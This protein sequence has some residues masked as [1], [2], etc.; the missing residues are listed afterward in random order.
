MSIIITRV[1]KAL[2]HD[3]TSDY[4]GWC[5]QGRKAYPGEIQRK[6]QS[7]LLGQI[8]FEQVGIIQQWLLIISHSL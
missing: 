7:F 6:A 4:C 1:E 3:E 5:E 2:K 8:H